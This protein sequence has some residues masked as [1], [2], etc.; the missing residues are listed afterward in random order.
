MGETFLSVGSVSA[1]TENF[2][3]VLKPTPD[4]G[5]I[6]PVCLF[7]RVPENY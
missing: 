5:A 7:K 6:Q 3:A 2:A 4:G 1:D